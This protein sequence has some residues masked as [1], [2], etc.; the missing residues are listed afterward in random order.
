M[1]ERAD[2]L[3]NQAILLAHNGQFS[4]ALACL[5]RAIQIDRKNSLIWYNLGITYRDSGDLP[6]AMEA[7]KNAFSISPDKEDIVET[8]CVVCM[9]L[10]LMDKAFEYCEEGLDLH[11]VSAKLWNLMG[12]LQFNDNDFSGA[13]ESFEMAVT[14]NPYYKDALY[15]LHDTYVE[16]H[17]PHG[18]KVT[19]S[20]IKELEG[21]K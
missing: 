4:E 13:S 18:V 5:R 7:L 16:Q 12:V 8:L 15:N 19:A 21:T 9:N 3:N 14:I 2:T 10:H 20:R 11:P 17:N 1:K 6:N